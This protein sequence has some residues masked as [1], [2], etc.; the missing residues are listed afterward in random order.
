MFLKKSD[1]ELQ[2]EIDTALDEIFKG[3]NDDSFSDVIE[4]AQNCDGSI[5]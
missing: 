4:L 3:S 5:F 1:D 2:E